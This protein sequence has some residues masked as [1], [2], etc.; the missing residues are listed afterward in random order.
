[1]VA[2]N[3]AHCE[4]VKK[5]KG[6]GKREK[7]LM[8]ERDKERKRELT[9]DDFCCLSMQLGEFDRPTHLTVTKT[10]KVN[11]RNSSIKKRFSIIFQ[12]VFQIEFK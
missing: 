2:V 6:K 5:K 4:S 8:G 9:C 11:Y 7:C 1:M 10:E 3:A 12:I